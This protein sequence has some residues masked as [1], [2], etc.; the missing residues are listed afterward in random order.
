MNNFNLIE[1]LIIP[2]I[3]G[4]ELSQVSIHLN[5]LSNSYDQNALIFFQAKINDEKKTEILTR[6]LPSKSSYYLEEYQDWCKKLKIDDQ[7]IHFLEYLSFKG[8]NRFNYLIKQI[9]KTKAPFKYHHLYIGSM[10]GIIGAGIYFIQNQVAWINFLELLKTEL[11][12]LF[13]Q[14]IEW[15]SCPKN[16]ALVMLLY[17]LTR[18]LIDFYYILSDHSLNKTD[19]IKRLCHLSLNFLLNSAAQLTIFLELPWSYLSGLIFFLNNLI[20]I[21]WIIAER[22]FLNKPRLG[23][24]P[25]NLDRLSQVHWEEQENHYERLQKQLYIEGI[26]LFMTLIVSVLSICFA[27]NI[28]CMASLSAGFQFLLALTKTHYCNVIEKKFAAKLQNK[29][30]TIHQLPAPSADIEEEAMVLSCV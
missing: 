17:Q 11:P 20:N 13:F 18:Y 10:F 27:P 14:A 7:L 30:G 6:L 21:A 16:L 28:A 22:Y 15:I 29:V 19:K 3:E 26:S 8:F 12:H 24:D 5:A 1:N 4:L 9:Y 23:F 25:R 2:Y